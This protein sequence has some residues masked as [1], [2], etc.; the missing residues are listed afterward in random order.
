MI[1]KM[2]VKE[3]NNCVTTIPSDIPSLKKYPQRML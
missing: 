3:K 1:A 2:T